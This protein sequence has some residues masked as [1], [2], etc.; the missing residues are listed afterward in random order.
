MNKIG[1][2]L[3]FSLVF[4]LQ[5]QA[6]NN[7]AT[8]DGI[9]ATSTALPFSKYSVTNIF[10]N[11]N[12]TYWRTISG[13][14]PDEGIMIY[15]SKPTYINRV[16]PV[17]YSGDNLDA[18][19]SFEV[20][21]NGTTLWRGK[22]IERELSSLYIRITS[23]K[24]S[25]NISGSYKDAKYYRHAFDQDFSIAISELEIF[26]KD[27]KPLKI[28]TPEYI[29]G[30]ISTS[31]T[32]NPDIAYGPD[33]LMDCK[34]EFGWAEGSKGNGIGD[35]IKFHT[36][37]PI[38]INK[39]KIWNGY[40]RSQ[41]HFKSN[42]RLKTFQFGVA[43]SSLETYTL[44]DMEGDQ[45]IPLK[46]T[47]SGRDFVLI[48]N[49]AYAGSAYQDLV[50]SEIHFL[51]NDKTT[52]IRS[53]N[54]EKN[55]DKLKSNA[56]EILRNYLDKNISVSLSKRNEFENES[57][58]YY[59]TNSLI[60]RSNQSFVLYQ[61]QTS[62]IEGMDEEDDYY[63]SEDTNEIIADGNWELIETGEGFV[64][65]RIFGKIYS[66]TTLTELYQGEVTSDN[67]RIFQ[68]QLTLTKELISGQKFV[69]D[70]AIQN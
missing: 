58:Y 47:L 69:E 67:V 37:H 68:D 11:N 38:T 14:G 43:G 17:F 34:K 5:L 63:A 53:N 12:S 65:I 29:N 40:Q 26:G 35:E 2:L 51:R 3:C 55:I 16:N 70:I 24:H 39:L 1:L 15:F 4:N 27:D 48:I 44:A 32:L 23:S 52:L 56:P 13:A 42:A 66:P 19:P 50:I 8:L 6:Q 36:N 7:E 10:D 22:S 20:Y 62:S 25:K 64:K 60:I 45:T 18:E 46:Q 33:N 28:I 57:E 59:E 21:G 49:D 30:V 31:S 54:R 41:K 9:Y 61:M